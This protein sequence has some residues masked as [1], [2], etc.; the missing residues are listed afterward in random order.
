MGRL[1][2]IYRRYA[3]GKV[4]EQIGHHQLIGHLVRNNLLPDFQSAYRKGH[5]TETAVLNVFS[6]VVDGIEKGQFGLLSLLNLTTAF[7]TVDHEI[8]L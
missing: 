5:S 8:L 7:D 3:V 4:L 2:K 1:F 6:D